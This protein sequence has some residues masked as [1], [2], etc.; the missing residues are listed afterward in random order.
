MAIAWPSSVIP[1]GQSERII[2]PW[3][4][5][6]S[7]L[8]ETS[9]D[10]GSST[11]LWQIDYSFPPISKAQVLAVKSALA[12][13]TGNEF[14]VPIYQTGINLPPAMTT[15]LSAAA[16]N[17]SIPVQGLNSAYA[18][19]AGQLISI[20]DGGRRYVYALGTDSAAGSTS[21][22]F[23]LANAVRRPHSAGCVVEI[24]QPY[25]QGSIPPD[26]RQID[27]DVALI[28]GFSLSIREKR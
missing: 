3:T 12:K 20:I 10:S 6:T 21:R 22:T 28:A 27:L 14:I 19:I 1:N 18:L 4:T 17:F 25:V 7:Q 5:Y 23:T 24:T 26:K 8:T 2:A 15:T 11:A 9:Q 13:S 16:S